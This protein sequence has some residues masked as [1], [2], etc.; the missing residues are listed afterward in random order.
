MSS[1]KSCISTLLKATSDILTVAAAST[2]KSVSLSSPK[3]I[4]VQKIPKIVR[5]SMT[6]L[7]RKFNSCKQFHT[8]DPRH[9]KAAALLRIAKTA[10]RRLIRNI[11]S[12]VNFKEDQKMFALLSYKPASVFR[13]IRSLKT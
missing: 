13:K 9:G 2:N 8:D 12:T 10:H 7:K 5:K 3:Q 11:N 4:K 1:S 6:Q